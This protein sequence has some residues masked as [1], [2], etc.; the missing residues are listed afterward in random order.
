VLRVA[1]VDDQP[2]TRSGMDRVVSMSPRLTVVASVSRADDL[3]AGV[4]G[5]DVVVLALPTQSAGPSLEIIAKVAAIGRPLVTAA[6]DQ[7]PTLLAALRAGAHG[8]LTRYSPESAVLDAMVVVAQGGLFLCSQLVDQF[9]AEL[10]RPRQNEATGLAP[11]EIET[12]RWI[13]LGFTQAQIANR[14]GLSE[15][16][17]NTYAKRIRGK[18]HVGNKADLTRVAIA[19]GY[20][21]SD[22]Q[23][24]AA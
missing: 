22:R 5:C 6:W 12:L 7:P 15:A 2:V 14:M 20:L 21:S 23:H 9:E 18:L 19:L 1:I 11:R 24:H 10:H 8:C 4:V 17:V 3:P 16:T 13:A